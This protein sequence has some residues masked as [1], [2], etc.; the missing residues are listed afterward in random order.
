MAHLSMIF[1]ARYLHLF[2][3]ANQMVSHHQPPRPPRQDPWAL[4]AVPAENG[5]IDRIRVTNLGFARSLA[6]EPG[7]RFLMAFKDHHIK[8]MIIIDMIRYD[9][10]HLWHI[11]FFRFLIYDTLNWS[12]HYLDPW[13]MDMF[14][15]GILSSS[16][17]RLKQPQTFNVKARHLAQLSTRRY[18]IMLSLQFRLSRS[19]STS[20]DNH[21]PDSSRAKFG[22]HNRT[23]GA[24]YF[25]HLQHF[26]GLRPLVDAEILSPLTEGSGTVSPTM[27]IIRMTEQLCW[28]IALWALSW[29]WS[30]LIMQMQVAAIPIWRIF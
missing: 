23:V 2:S 27:S 25:S 14:T 8:D 13:L 26:E 20:P 16:P 12:T 4:R 5:A 3:M 19:L 10:I 1:P 30:S 15:I 11:F 21:L 18:W 6:Q 22:S 9:M 7:V 24:R 17:K 29:H 28:C